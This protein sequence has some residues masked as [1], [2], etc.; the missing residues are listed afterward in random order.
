MDP[1]LEHKNKL[2]AAAAKADIP[3]YRAKSGW[4]VTLLDVIS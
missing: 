1:S 4:Y 3:R 2:A